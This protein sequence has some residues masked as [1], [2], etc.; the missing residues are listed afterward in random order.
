VKHREKSSGLCV[1]EARGDLVG[2]GGEIP[3]AARS[4]GVVTGAVVALTPDG[5]PLVDWSQDMTAMPLRARSCVALKPDDV[6]ACA[7]LAFEGGDPSKPIVLGLLDP[8]AR[9]PASVVS[10]A[11]GPTQ[12]R[13]ET[14]VEVDGRTITLTAMEHITLR[15]G[16]ASITLTREGKVIVRGTQVVSHASG[17]NRVRGGSVQLN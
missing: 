14:E 4:T 8:E 5:A 9:Q 1:E 17:V 15:C 7:V 13:A 2:V 3:L 11:L 10:K 6:G 12:L 16:S